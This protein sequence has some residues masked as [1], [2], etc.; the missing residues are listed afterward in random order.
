M[1]GIDTWDA[2]RNV[3]SQKDLWHTSLTIKTR[4]RVR[5]DRRLREC[6]VAWIMSMIRRKFA[7][8]ALYT[9]LSNIEKGQI[10]IAAIWSSNAAIFWSS[11]SKDSNFEILDSIAWNLQTIDASILYMEK[12]HLSKHVKGSNPLKFKSKFYSTRC[13][14]LIN[15]SEV[16]IC[17]IFWNTREDYETFRDPTRI[18]QL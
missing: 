15:D 16:A 14:K 18:I 12:D 3:P 10:Y 7:R 13:E 11:V 6:N 2:A 1:H 9:K 4:S 5:H 17:T 8:V